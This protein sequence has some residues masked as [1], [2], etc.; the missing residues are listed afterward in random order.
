MTKL[1]KYKSVLGNMT[2][3]TEDDRLVGLWFDGQKYDR[4]NIQSFEVEEAMTNIAK[5]TIRWLDDY[6][7]GQQ[8]SFSIPLKLKGTDFQKVVWQCLLTIPYGE[9]VTYGDV[10]DLVCKQ[11]HCK[12]WQIKQSAAR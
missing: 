12:K 3:A 11:L 6:F 4:W 2:I 1:N 5:L 7:S 8:P 9:A 10:R